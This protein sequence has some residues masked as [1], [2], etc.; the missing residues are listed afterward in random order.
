MSWRVF[1]VA[2]NFAKR[3][4]RKLNRKENRLH[5]SQQEKYEMPP[6]HW[7]KEEPLG[8]SE[9]PTSFLPL[10]VIHHLLG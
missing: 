5:I 4:R 6:R 9:S 8:L 2:L 1:G 3:R 7:E 10:A